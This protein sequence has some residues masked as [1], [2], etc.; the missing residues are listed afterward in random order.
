MLVHDSNDDDRQGKYRGDLGAWENHQGWPIGRAAGGLHPDWFL[1]G[2]VGDAAIAG[3]A[4]A[5]VHL[6]VACTCRCLPVPACFV[7]VAVRLP[8]TETAS[9]AE[10][11]RPPVPCQTR[12]NRFASPLK[13]LARY[14]NGILSTLGPSALSCHLLLVL[15]RMGA[16]ETH[17]QVNRDLYFKGPSSPLA[18]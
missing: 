2:H 7:P 16:H 15:V 6:R 3:P 5:N 11:R 10:K 14:P 17:R 12:L 1:T 8:L 18:R 13:K 4:C 9:V